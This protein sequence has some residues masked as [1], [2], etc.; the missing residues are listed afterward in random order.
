MAIMELESLIRE[1]KQ[2]DCTTDNLIAH[3]QV[4][5][6]AYYR[7]HPINYGFEEQVKHLLG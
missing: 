7:K 1:Y 3:S 5:L 2:G 6:D 4:T